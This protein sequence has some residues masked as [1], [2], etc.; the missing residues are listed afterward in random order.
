M[1]KKLYV[2]TNPELG[3]DC[4]V[5]VFRADSEDAVYQHIANERSR[6]VQDIKDEY[7]VHHKPYIREI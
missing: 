5:G 2:V 3:W 1:D 6:D 4:V 7:V